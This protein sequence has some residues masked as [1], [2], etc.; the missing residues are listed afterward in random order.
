MRSV[1]HPF[2]KLPRLWTILALAASPA[3]AQSLNI[4][5]GATAGTN[6]TPAYGAAAAQPGFWSWEQPI[7]GSIQPVSNLAGAASGVALEITGGVGGMMF[8]NAGT[9]GEDQDLMDDGL[10]VGGAGAVVDW[11]FHGLMADGY[12]VYTYAWAPDVAAWRTRV[13]VVEAG[14]VDSFDPDQDIGRAWPGFQKYVETYALHFVVVPP[15]AD[16]VVRTTTI[17]GLGRVQGFQLVRSGGACDGRILEYCVGK[18][19]S[20]G[21]LPDIG[22]FGVEPSAS[23]AAAG[24]FNITGSNILCNKTGL[25]LTSITGAAEL[26]FGGGTRCVGS[27]KRSPGQNSGCAGGAPCGGDFIL[28]FNAWI[29]TIPAASPYFVPLHTPGTSVWVQ[30][31]YRDPGFAAPNNVGLTNAMH[32][33]MCF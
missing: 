1:L 26:P 24:A 23:G 7:P 28:D 2:F 16:L 20:A 25:L 9:F 21:C 17:V 31:Y 18:V 4:D 22:S 19:N 12:W 27:F 30:W 8:N 13:S 10:D 3:T 29:D 11:T 14:G 32:F 15:G 33:T 5:V 6:P